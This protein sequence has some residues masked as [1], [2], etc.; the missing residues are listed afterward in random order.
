[1]PGWRGE[2]LLRLWN[3]V[4]LW[5]RYSDRLFLPALVGGDDAERRG[6]KKKRPPQKAAATIWPARIGERLAV[7]AGAGE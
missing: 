3:D 7:R 4:G 2:E 1:M 6:A 5:L